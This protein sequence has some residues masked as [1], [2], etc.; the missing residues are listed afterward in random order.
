MDHGITESSVIQR[1][2]SLR[3]GLL[4]LMVV[5]ILLG[6]GVG[7]AASSLSTLLDGSEVWG[8]AVGIIISAFSISYLF[9]KILSPKTHVFLFEGFLHLVQGDKTIQVRPAERFELSE[10]ISK[11]LQAAFSENPALLAAWLKNP[12]QCLP[13]QTT[14]IGSLIGNSLLDQAIEYFFLDRLSLHLSAYFQEHGIEEEKCQKFVRSDIPDV[15]LQNRFLEMFSKPMEEREQFSR[16]AH[17][18]ED[19]DQPCGTVVVAFG[20]DGALFDMFE[21]ILPKGSKVSRSAEGILRIETS[22]FFMEFEPGMEG[23]ATVTRRGFEEFYMHEPDLCEGAPTLVNSKMRVRV[24]RRALFSR[25]G[26]DYYR[27]LDSFIY[28]Y[29][30]EAHAD[31][32]Y[33]AI[34][35]ETALT[36][37][38]L[39]PPF[40]SQSKEEAE[41]GAPQD[42]ECAGAPSPP[43]S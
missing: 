8:I 4:E 20:T 40:M 22:I 28:E 27:W 2:E 31:R 25:S 16:H 42:G 1:L 17:G 24:K 10:N 14:G 13:G 30:E 11:Y 33:K 19:P 37:S 32:F 34:G 43:V 39:T 21:L 7:L 5:A 15:L 9:L 29:Y 38:R 18:T 35:W 12:V 41:H 36:I 23:F 6:F 3:S 26:W